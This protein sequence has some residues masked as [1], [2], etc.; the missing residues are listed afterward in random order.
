MKILFILLFIVYAVTYSSAQIKLTN[1]LYT[2]SSIMSEINQ[3][4][5]I[6]FVRSSLNNSIFNIEKE[7]DLSIFDK[8]MSIPKDYAHSIDL[9]CNNST[10]RLGSTSKIVNMHILDSIY[11][12]NTESFKRNLFYYD[13]KLNC[14]KI[15]IEVFDSAAILW[16][17]GAVIEFVYNSKNQNTKID[18]RVW[19][20]TLGK[21]TNYDTYIYDYD[22]KGRIILYE[23]YEGNNANSYSYKRKKYEYYYPEFYV[24]KKNSYAINE[25]WIPSDSTVLKYGSDDLLIFQEVFDYDE[26]SKSF[27]KYIKADYFFNSSGALIKAVQ[28]NWSSSYSSWQYKYKAEHLKNNQGFD[29]LE[30]YSNYYGSWRVENLVKY[31]VTPYG[32]H[33]LI[34][35]QHWG[36]AN[37]N[38]VKDS[39]DDIIYDSRQRE[40]QIESFIWDDYYHKWNIA[41]GYRIDYVV[42]ANDSVAIYSIYNN[43][44]YIPYSKDIYLTDSQIPNS[45][46]IP[47]LAFVD[48]PTN[49]KLIYEGAFYLNDDTTIHELGYEKKYYYSTKDTGSVDVLPKDVFFIVFPNP[50]NDYVIFQYDDSKHKAE[51]FLYDAL[52]R[53]VLNKKV[54]S[55]ENLSVKSIS[56]GSYLYRVY[57]GSDVYIGKLIFY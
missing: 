12:I 9:Q 38:W 31:E 30:I 33:T 32:K 34:E 7:I 6:D 25:K 8:L 4:F 24:I 28:S 50:T 20:N 48:K 51:V 56:A 46:V 1:E 41:Q 44:V 47:S 14:N 49:H 22:N 5:Q 19:S 21:W 53:L 23:Y 40:Y 17:P 55:N 45:Q 57:I 18:L 35:R 29:S 13:G 37:H 52:G 36:D 27:V 39:K 16:R 11:V 3:A 15:V 26:T 2:R 43:G 54:L 42:S 10:F